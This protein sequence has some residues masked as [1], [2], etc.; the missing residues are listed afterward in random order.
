MNT[1]VCKAESLLPLKVA[2]PSAVTLFWVWALNFGE[3]SCSSAPSPF[4]PKL[5]MPA[6][7]A[8]LFKCS[9]LEGGLFLA[10]LRARKDPLDDDTRPVVTYGVACTSSG[11]WDACGTVC[12]RRWWLLCVGAFFPPLIVQEMRCQDITGLCDSWMRVRSPHDGGTV[13]FHII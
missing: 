12:R 5:L 7:A 2:C 6:I 10:P 8:M 4:V 3:F 9:Y 11:V 1:G 13:V